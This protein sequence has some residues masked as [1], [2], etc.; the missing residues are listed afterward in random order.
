MSPSCKGHESATGVMH[1][2]FFELQLLSGDPAQSDQPIG[3]S[4]SHDAACLTISSLPDGRS[5]PDVGADILVSR[6]VNHGLLDLVL[7]STSSF[8]LVGLGL[9]VAPVSP[10]P[11]PRCE[12]S[13]DSPS[14]SL[15][16]LSPGL[17]G[18][19]GVL[20]SETTA[21]L[22]GG[23]GKLARHGLIDAGLVG[24]EAGQRGSSQRSVSSRERSCS[25]GGT[26]QNRIAWRCPSWTGTS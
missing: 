19:R 8:E 20:A 2:T 17:V 24:C 4:S 10:C 12:S 26:H 7:R 18:Q 13:S 9:S 21:D 11:V 25:S 22:D 3:S 16:E 6:S 23:A 15:V 5:L 14:S 1:A